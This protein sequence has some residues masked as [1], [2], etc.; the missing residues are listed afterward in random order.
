MQDRMQRF[1]RNAGTKPL[2]PWGERFISCHPGINKIPRIET[3]I[4]SV[5]EIPLAGIEAESLVNHEGLISIS[6]TG[7]G[8]L[9][10]KKRLPPVGVAGPFVE[11]QHPREIVQILNL[12]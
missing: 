1:F 6:V 7:F 2:Q 12:A 9:P 11:D 4:R 10:P 5:R 3:A 8:S